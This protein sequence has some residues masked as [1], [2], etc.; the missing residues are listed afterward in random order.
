MVLDGKTGDELLSFY[1][2]DPSFK[3]GV[4]V[5]AVDM[6]GTPDIVVA[7]GAGGGPEIRVFNGLTGALIESFYAFD[8]SFKGGVS[9]SAASNLTGNGD[10]D[11][12]VGAGVGGAPRVA[13]FDLTT[14][15]QV[16]GPLGSFYAFDSLMRTGVSVS[17]DT[18][19]SDVTDAGHPDIVVGTG[20]GVSSEVK[21][22]SGADGSVLRDFTPYAAGMTA[23][24]TVATAYVDD[25][26]FADIIVGTDVGVPT[27]VKIFSGQTGQLVSLPTADIPPFGDSFTGGV[28]LAASNDPP[29][30][31]FSILPGQIV[32]AGD[33][34]TAVGTVTSSVPLTGVT[35]SVDWGDGSSPVSSGFMETWNSSTSISFTSPSYAYTEPGQYTVTITANTTYVGGTDSG[36]GSDTE[37]VVISDPGGGGGSTS[38]GNDGGGDTSAEVWLD[39]ALQSIPDG[40][41]GSVYVERT[42]G[43]TTQPLTVNLGIGADGEG[44]PQAVWGT[45]YSLSAS[46]SGG[47]SLTPSGGT[48]TFAAN[49][50]DVNLMVATTPT[51]IIEGTV[52]FGVTLLGGDGYYGPPSGTGL[53]TTAN[54]QILDTPPV[55][56]TTSLNPAAVGQ[57]VTLTATIGPIQAGAPTPTGTI[58]FMDGS[59]PLGTAPL[60]TSGDSVVASLVTSAL[61]EGTDTLTASY[62]GDGEYSASTS[63]PVTE[64]ITG[65]A[66]TTVVTSSANPSE[67][68][69]SVTYTATVSASAGGGTPTGWV[70]FG[71]DGVNQTSVQLSSNG[72][73]AWT[74]LTSLA[75]GSHTITASYA[76]TSSYGASSGSIVETVQA[77][78]ITGTVWVD[79]NG[80]YNDDPGD[81]GL[82]GVTVTLSTL[83]MGD[84]V[85][86]TTT[87]INGDFSFANVPVGSYTVSFSPPG[88]YVM[89]TASLSVPQSGSVSA[90]A[91]LPNTIT[92]TAFVDNNQDGVQDD[93]EPGLPGVSVTMLD[94]QNGNISGPITTGSNGQYT[95]SNLAPGTYT[96]N[97][98]APSG[99][100]LSGSSN[101]TWK[102]AT[103]TS[104]DTQMVNVPAYSAGITNS[105]ISGTLWVD[106]NGDYTDDPGDPVL[107]GVPVTLFTSSGASIGSTTTDSNGDFSFGGLSAGTYT[108]TFST[109]SG[110]VIESTPVT[111][112]TPGPESF[113]SVGAYQPDTITGTAFLDLNNDQ[114]DDPGD[115]GVA[116]LSVTMVDQIGHSYGPVTTDSN[117]NYTFSNLAPGTYQM[118]FTAP[119]GYVLNGSSNTSS[120]SMTVTSDD[121]EPQDVPVYSATALT[122]VSGTVF[123]DSNGDYTND[124]GDPGLAGAT[125]TLFNWWDVNVGKTTTDSNGDFSF[126]NL[127]PGTYTAAFTP[128]SGYVMESASVTAV[129][130]GAGTVVS[131]GAY[132]PDTISGTVFVDSNQDGVQDD[133]ESGLPGVTVTMTDANGNTY[134]PITT[135]SNGNYS[136]S[137]LAPGTYTV[138]FTAPSG[139]VVN[140]SANT[141]SG[142][143]TVTS[144]DSETLDAPAYSATTLVTLSGTVFLDINGDDTDDTGDPTQAGVTVT[145]VNSSGFEVGS[146]TTD[147]TGAFS[148]PWLPVGTYTAVFSAPGGYVMETTSVRAALPGSSSVLSVGVYQPDTITGTAF[149]DINNDQTDDTGD[150]AIAGAIVTMTD[151]NGNT[152]GPITTGSDGSYSF[153]NLAPGAYTL[154]FTAPSGYVM[155]GTSNTWTTSVSVSSNDTETANIPIYPSTQLGTVS[156]VAWL[157]RNGDQNFETGDTGLAGVTV[158]LDESNGQ[159]ESVTTSADGSYAFSN[160]PAG[161]YTLVFA[162]A[163]GAKIENS[164]SSTWSGTV[165]TPGPNSVLDVGMLTTILVGAVAPQVNAE[166]DLVSLPIQVVANSTGDNPVFSA[167]GLP[168]GLT[169]DP[170]TGIISGQPLYTDAQTNGG[171]YPVSVTATAGGVSDTMSFNWTIDDV[172]RL[173]PINDF[174]STTDASGNFTLL[175]GSESN[176]NLVPDDIPAI[177]AVDLLGDPLTFTISIPAG[178]VTITGSLIQ[179]STTTWVAAVSGQLPNVTAAYQASVSVTGGGATDSQ[180]FTW[181]NNATNDTTNNFYP[182][183]NGTVTTTDDATPVGSDATVGYVVSGAA[184]MAG[185]TITFSIESGQ[186]AFDGPSSFSFPGS[187]SGSPIYLGTAITALGVS[188]AIIDA[189]YEQ[190]AAPVKI[191]LAVQTVHM[192]T[193]AFVSG[194]GFEIAQQVTGQQ[195]PPTMKENRIPPTAE[196]KTLLMVKGNVAN[197]NFATMCIGQSPVNGMITINGGQTV[198]GKLFA[199]NTIQGLTAAQQAV[200]NGFAPNFAG[201]LT[202]VGQ[203]STAPPANGQKAGVNAN[204]L[205]LAISVGGF[206]VKAFFTSP[207]FSVAAIPIAVE[208]KKDTAPTP[209]LIDLGNNEWSVAYGQVFRMKFTSDSGDASDLVKGISIKEMVV[210][211]KGTGFFDGQGSGKSNP[212]Y[213]SLQEAV[214]DG[215]QIVDFV[216]PTPVTVTALTAAMAAKLGTNKLF[217][218]L[219]A[220]SNKTSP[221]TL[222]GTLTNNQYIIFADS[223]TGATDIKIPE[224]GFTNT[225][226]VTKLDATSFSISITKMPKDNNGVV[227]GIE[228]ELALKAV[229]LKLTQQQ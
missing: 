11:L 156:G 111:A 182:E 188:D 129:A 60:T 163:N 127:A 206:N 77:D 183:V 71:V 143:V 40:G 178:N 224:S 125:V 219:T 130:P 191:P 84:P 90:G 63:P 78:T 85:G 161:T 49:Q 171:S 199:A 38:G 67:Y 221:P 147:T 50:T 48:V 214:Q 106:S 83:S 24:V 98:I 110:Y 43:D 102:M 150:P 52:G 135:D 145:L 132:Q 170:N 104:D 93:G 99:Y 208:M 201:M 81:P 75:V 196:T 166:A 23:G 13:T 202:L 19:A 140:G 157:D 226:K 103:V 80:D 192:F 159:S 114:L 164:S 175:D 118:T 220:L 113:V 73:A 197:I 21:V 91:Y 137:Y 120:E 136:F 133:G 97:F 18:L 180:T 211:G 58:T 216:G 184:L 54:V 35:L 203:T 210:D 100:V 190:P 193:Y 15:T 134:G 96:A 154:T 62:S 152:Y 87:D 185:G 51:S 162:T 17:T 186:A 59:A 65:A 116:G 124:S 128:P 66:T 172:N 167:T 212:N 30:V 198:V 123:V 29:T 86:S 37:D 139:Y 151:Q 229:E 227:P 101:N 56:L 169:I 33:Q 144:N 92:G 207:G 204:Q 72:T 200:L 215:K 10:P 223:I 146:M 141:L 160:L 69:Q 222:T 213:T 39:P 20:P 153:S 32:G 109:P 195:T 31:M 174:F 155:D 12:V 28:N 34:V 27:E 173:L 42:G 217:D 26:P 187:T 74:P 68:G 89:E 194:P 6:N 177:E 5:A 131:V 55:E 46:G 1:A 14:G 47:S 148:F 176:G 168:V 7:A 70:T 108:L 8:P 179:G 36:S 76:G 112:E 119:S 138:N 121:T 142:S 44:D 117:G 4:T 115:P 16:A 94:D 149:G 189:D 2:F 105:S 181:Y 25:D 88:E 158:T 165:N 225:I 209:T 53:A 64:V 9:I 122:S 3:G 82:A 228:G 95:F 79:R 107:T 57:A 22:F 61:L 126:P 218:I 205:A 41:T 45:N